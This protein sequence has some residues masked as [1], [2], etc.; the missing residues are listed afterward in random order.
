ML[1]DCA[2]VVSLSRISWAWRRQG[3][4]PNDTRKTRLYRLGIQ[5][6]GNKGQSSRQLGV[7]KRIGSWGK[8][9]WPSSEQQWF[10]RRTG[11][12]IV[13]VSGKPA[14]VQTSA[15]PSSN[16]PIFCT[17]SCCGRKMATSVPSGHG[18][19]SSVPS[20]ISPL[21]SRILLLARTPPCAPGCPGWP[22][23]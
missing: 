11:P 19:D 2:F 4:S 7:D 14:G 23:C 6:G 8:S 10:G 5:S 22:A 17:L 13:R 1:V 20:A 12:G 15:W 18:R 21:T 16:K 3:S 9:E